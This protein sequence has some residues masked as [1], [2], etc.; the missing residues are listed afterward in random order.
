MKERL[1]FVYIWRDSKRN[2]YYVGSHVGAIDDGY[3]CS[4]KHMRQA[5]DRRPSDFKRKILYT[6]YGTREDLLKEESRWLSMIKEQE[7]KTKYYNR[8]RKTFGSESEVYSSWSKRYWSDPENRK[9]Q[10]ERMTGKKN[11]THSER[12][13]KMWADPEF[14]KKFDRSESNRKAWAGNDVR[15]Q[16]QSELMKA[17][18]NSLEVREKIRA[19]HVN[20]FADDPEYYRERAALARSHRAKKRFLK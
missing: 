16:K 13:K 10:S 8:E 14:K 19:Y 12:M 15:R 11:P 7:L 20:K 1:G 17:K 4:S 2:M 3:I 18:E 6:Q 9:T 5:Y